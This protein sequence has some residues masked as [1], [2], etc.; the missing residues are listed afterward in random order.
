MPPEAPYYSSSASPSMHQL[1]IIDI[2]FKAV[3]NATQMALQYFRRE[4]RKGVIINMASVTALFPWSIGPIY[5]ATKAAVLHFSLALTGLALKDNVRINVVCP[6]GTQS[7]I[8]SKYSQKDLAKFSTTLSGIQPASAVA[9]GV[10]RL[11]VEEQRAGAVLVVENNQL[12]YWTPPVYKSL[13][14]L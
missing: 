7:N 9:E 3:I 1:P 8:T 14:S 2:N 12:W 10:L 11:C 5:S 13:A 4:K 6:H